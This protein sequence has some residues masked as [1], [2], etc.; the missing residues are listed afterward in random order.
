MIDRLRS[1]ATSNTGVVG[2][3][4]P[5]VSCLPLLVHK[6]LKLSLSALLVRKAVE[7]GEYHHY[8]ER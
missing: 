2:W 1:G 8:T 7:T 3:H 4:V 6:Q 5:A